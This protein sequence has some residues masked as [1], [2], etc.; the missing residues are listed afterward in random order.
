MDP[1]NL[2]RKKLKGKNY[3]YNPKAFELIIIE[4]RY[5]CQSVSVYL[6]EIEQNGFWLISSCSFASVRLSVSLFICLTDCPYSFTHV[7]CVCVCVCVSERER[8]KERERMSEWRTFFKR[9]WMQMTNFMYTCKHL[10]KRTTATYKTLKKS[11][12]IMRN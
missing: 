6:F 1:R 5:I 4:W 7:S 10:W 9:L 12:I 8:E 11:W 3:W 2:F